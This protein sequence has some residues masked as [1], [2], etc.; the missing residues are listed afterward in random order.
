VTLSVK[1]PSEK[2][3]FSAWL[4]REKLGPKE[5]GRVLFRLT[6]Q[7]AGPR[8]PVV[9]TVSVQPTGQTIPV[10]VTVVAPAK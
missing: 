2:P 10:R 5:S 8:P 7:Q 6:E 9:V 4:E 1:L 3:G